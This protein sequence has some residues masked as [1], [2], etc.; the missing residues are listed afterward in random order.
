MAKSH[1]SAFAPSQGVGL[2]RPRV[3]QHSDTKSS[4]HQF[5]WSREDVY[6]V[7]FLGRSPSLPGLERLGKE[8]TCLQGRGSCPKWVAVEFGSSRHSLGEGRQRNQDTGIWEKRQYGQQLD[9]WSGTNRKD[10]RSRR[11]PRADGK[12]P[13]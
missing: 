6:M 1:P 8:G 9:F 4:K 3:S 5:G 13:Q 7:G 12:Q 11:G 10:L 2:G